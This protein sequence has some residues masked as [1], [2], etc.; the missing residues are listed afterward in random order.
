MDRPSRASA[1]GEVLLG[2]N[3]KLRPCENCRGKGCAACAERSFDQD[4][5][6]E[7]TDWLED[8]GKEPV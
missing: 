1:A 8:T 7:L 6:V 2:A 4:G 5:R 3:T